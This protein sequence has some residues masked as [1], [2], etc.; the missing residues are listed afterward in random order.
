M[1][2]ST[3]EVIYDMTASLDRLGVHNGELYWDLQKYWELK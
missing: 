3:W 2:F 1:E